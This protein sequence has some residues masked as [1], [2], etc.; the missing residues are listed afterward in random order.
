L[1]GWDRPE[2]RNGLGRRPRRC[3]WR[4]WRRRRRWRRRELRCRRR[5]RVDG[6]GGTGCVADDR[7]KPRHGRLLRASLARRRF[8]DR[9]GR[10]HGGR[11]AFL[12]LS[13]RFLAWLQQHA[14][15][16]IGDLIG[17][18]AEL[19]FCLKDAAEPLVEERRQL[20]RGEP[21]LFGELKYPYFSG[22]IHS[23]A[24]CARVP[25]VGARSPSRRL[26]STR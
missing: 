5:R 14:A 26:G 9:L 7:T 6:R 13:G 15:D 12:W 16:Q 20:F 19:V 25:S 4:T 23:R 21:N 24:R 17:N 3:Y 10:G 18:D 8:G 2:L 22:Q 1:P 11:R